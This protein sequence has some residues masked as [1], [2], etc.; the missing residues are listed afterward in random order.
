MVD[1]A[2]YRIAPVKRPGAARTKAVLT[3]IARTVRFIRREFTAPVHLPLS[4]RW[5]GWRH[6]IGATTNVLYN[7]DA[8]GDPRL[9]LSDY[10]SMVR[11]HGISGPFN[12]LVANKLAFAR[13]MALNGFRH[14]RVYAYL[15]QGRA[16]PPDAPAEDARAWLDKHLAV[17]ECVVLKPAAAG[18]GQGIIFLARE[19]GGFSVNQVSA[20]NDE[21][22]TLVAPLRQYLITEFIRQADYAAAIYPE[23]TNTVRVLSLWDLDLGTPFIAA[24]AHRF[25]TSRSAPVDNWHGGRGGLSSAIAVET[26]VIGPGATLSA[27]RLVWHERHPESGA[28]IAGVHVPGWADVVATI[29]AASAR[30]P[31]TPAIGWDLVVTREGCCFL[32]GNTPPGVF[33]WQVHAP[34]LADPRV[35]RFYEA[36]GVV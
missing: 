6:G 28:A 30:V 16:H 31:E 32:E 22:A 9:Y 1:M 18:M 15:H 26:G 4:S 33:V 24:A 25:G 11:S 2:A 27:G 12:P 14:A 13:V 3:R 36:H 19:P 8:G 29:L 17:G 21:V 35:R 10:A 5:R 20:S 34:L 23:T 7:L